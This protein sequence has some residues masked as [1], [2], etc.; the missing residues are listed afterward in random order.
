MRPP[1]GE[2]LDE[3]LDMWHSDSWDCPGGKP[4]VSDEQL[5]HG[6]AVMADWFREEFALP[7]AKVANRP[8]TKADKGSQHRGRRLVERRSGGVCEIQ[9]EGVCVGPATD[10]CHR[11][12]RSQGGTW[13]PQNGLH[14]CHECHMWTHAHPS[15]ARVN[16]WACKSYDP[17]DTGVLR[18][19]EWV[20]LDEE[21]GFE[22]CPRKV[23]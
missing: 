20:V 2:R 3:A 13:S 1:E 17:I 5:S 7:K 21:G 8:A 22:R 9:V 6:L 14:G 15:T 18:R 16:G 11:R 19:G 12:A 23:A 10:W 4:R